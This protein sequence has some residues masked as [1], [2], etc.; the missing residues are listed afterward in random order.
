MFSNFQGNGDEL[1]ISPSYDLQEA[2]SSY[3]IKSTAIDISKIID[4]T[5]DLS[6]HGYIE[7]DGFSY[8]VK[9][10]LK[11]KLPSSFE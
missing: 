5:K 7:N 4:Y 1:Q 6:I 11:L 8:S 10:I 2:F 3:G 9:T